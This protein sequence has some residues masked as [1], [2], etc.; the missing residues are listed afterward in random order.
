MLKFVQNRQKRKEWDRDDDESGTDE[1]DNSDNDSNSGSEHSA[2]NSEDESNPGSNL[3]DSEEGELGLGADD[4]LA[5]PLV[6][7]IDDEE[8]TLCLICP[9]KLLKNPAMVDVHASSAVRPVVSINLPPN[10]S[11]LSLPPIWI[12]PLFALFRV[13]YVVLNALSDAP[14]SWKLKMANIRLYML[15]CIGWTPQQPTL[16]QRNEKYVTCGSYSL[17]PVL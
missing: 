4:I 12:Y 16:P 14:R 15:F 17:S 9:G 8:I 7:D 10:Y 1:D 3:S 2:S 5:R 13:I 11:S 6:P